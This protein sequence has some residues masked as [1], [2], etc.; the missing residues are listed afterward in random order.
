M[1]N[2]ARGLLDQVLEFIDTLTGTE[3]KYQTKV[4]NKNEGG[5]SKVVVRK[6]LADRPSYRNKA[7]DQFHDKFIVNAFRR[8]KD[9][10]GNTQI[11]RDFYITQVVTQNLSDNHRAVYSVPT[12]SFHRYFMLLPSAT[13]P[14]HVRFAD[15]SK[16]TDARILRMTDDVFNSFFFKSTHSL[17]RERM[18]RTPPLCVSASDYFGDS[19][20]GTIAQ[21]PLP[22]DMKTMVRIIDDRERA[23]VAAGVQVS[24]DSAAYGTE[25]NPRPVA[26]QPQNDGP[27]DTNEEAEEEEEQTPPPESLQLVVDVEPTADQMYSNDEARTPLSFITLQDARD[28]LKCCVDK[29]SKSTYPSLTP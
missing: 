23:R 15:A 18:I 4:I 7:L 24:Q 25:G 9:N 10:K 11:G 28:Q 3:L 21:H 19:C 2:K 5:I 12:V 22:R 1:T 29:L 16:W 20:K 8:Y 13:R 17:G 6:P 27:D 26:D 14:T